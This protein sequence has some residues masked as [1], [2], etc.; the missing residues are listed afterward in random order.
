MTGDPDQVLVTTG[1]LFHP[2]ASATRVHHRHYPEIEVEGTSALEAAEALLRHL[3]AA[4][5]DSPNRWHRGQLEQARDDVG[6]FVARIRRSGARRRASL[7]REPS[8][9]GPF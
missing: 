5:D 2:A 6:A 3:A 4:L 9:R 7:S 8:P 1:D